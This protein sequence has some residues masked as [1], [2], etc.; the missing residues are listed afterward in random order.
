MGGKGKEPEGWQAEATVTQ[1]GKQ[2][3]GHTH[4][5]PFPTS[6]LV[7][8]WLF[9][10]VYFL[11][12]RTGG[13]LMNKG[14]PSEKNP[15]PNSILLPASR[16]YITRGTFSTGLPLLPGPLPLSSSL[17]KNT[18]KP[19]NASFQAPKQPISLEA[20]RVTVQVGV[21]VQRRGNT[22]RDRRL[23]GRFLSPSKVRGGLRLDT[24]S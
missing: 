16:P 3:P 4:C 19:R 2:A 23:S 6:R 11:Q 13:R 12:G 14:T 9:L 17:L 21:S 24:G 15:K 1:L 5:P 7:C 10:F 8:V 20:S 18:R 22:F